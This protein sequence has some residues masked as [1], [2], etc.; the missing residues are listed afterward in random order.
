MNLDT[1]KPFESGNNAIENGRKGGLKSVEER[2]KKKLFKEI[3]KDILNQTP[4]SEE[5]KDLLNRYTSLDLEDITYRTLIVDKQIKKALNG[6]TKA[7][8][9]ILNMSGEKPKGNEIQNEPTII[10]VSLKD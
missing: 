9:L 5:V 10:T 1:L 2:R 3:V 6:D 4:T 8:D 7:C